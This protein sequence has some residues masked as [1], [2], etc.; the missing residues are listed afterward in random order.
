MSGG[1]A[2]TS[3]GILRSNSHGAG[4]ECQLEDEYVLAGGCG[5]LSVYYSFYI[6]FCFLLSARGW[7]RHYG[8]TVAGY[9]FLDSSPWYTGRLEQ[10]KYGSCRVAPECGR[11]PD[12][13]E[14]K[15]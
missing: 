7:G 3:G 15:E 5:E 8:V 4:T 11:Y 9:C 14:E 6:A 13:S 12:H 2:E 1:S 10:R